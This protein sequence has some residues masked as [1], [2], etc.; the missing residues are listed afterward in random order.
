[1]VYIKIDNLP[2][3]KGIYL[4]TYISHNQ[5]MEGIAAFSTI[6]FLGYIGSYGLA[7]KL[8]MDAY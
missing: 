3:F 7:L 4:P 2:V 6:Y 5:G 8:I 1:M